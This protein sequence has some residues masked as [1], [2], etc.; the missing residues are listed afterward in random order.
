LGPSGSDAKLQRFSLGVTEPQPLTDSSEFWTVA[1]HGAVIGIFLL[2]FG[3]VL[4]VSRSILLPVLAAV[5]VGT[6]LGPVAAWTA[7]YKVP[8]WLFAFLSV[9]FVIIAINVAIMLL[10]GPVTEWIAKAPEIGATVGQK[11]QILDRPLAALRELQ[12]AV[13]APLA[14]N[15]GSLKV[16]VSQGNFFAPLIAVMTPAVGEI[17]L[18]FGTLFFYQLGR[19]AHRQVLI[20]LFATQD[21][22]LRALRILGDAEQNLAR[23][24]G[25]VTVINIFVGVGTGIIAYV[26]GLPNAALWAVLAFVLNYLPYIGPAIMFLVL[27]VVGLIALP[28]LFHA[29]VPPLV[30]AT[31]TTVEGHFI[32]PGIIG[33]QLELSPL[34]VF[35]S[36]AFWTWLWGPA[37]AFLA[38]PFLIVGLV[39]FGHVYPKHRMK[40]PE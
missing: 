2:L 6:M 34:A 14:K 27:F 40:L 22:R 24:V 19:A 25:V 15:D 18:F 32:T 17:L 30:F 8:A 28:T 9:L 37:G 1:A 33:R 10:A 20:S 39:V 11:L 13:M 23:Y 7:R 3:A 29:L 4:Y 21:A 36:L 5:I 16:D 31:L 38:V 12:A 26:F 35:L